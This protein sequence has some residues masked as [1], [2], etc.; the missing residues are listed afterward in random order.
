MACTDEGARSSIHESE[1]PWCMSY[2]ARALHP[3]QA[4]RVCGR[5][6]SFVVVDA[7][8]LPSVPGGRCRAG[9]CPPA[10]TSPR[11]TW[12]SAASLMV[13]SS[14]VSGGMRRTPDS[15]SWTAR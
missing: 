3:D 12:R 1:S 7:I 5:R 8:R 4:E 10:A 14:Q 15:H 13:I 11:F 6:R 2:N 9:G